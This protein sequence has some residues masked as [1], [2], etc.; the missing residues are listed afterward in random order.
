MPITV[1]I[2]KGSELF[3]AKTE[4]IYTLD[5]DQ[6][7]VLE[8]SLVSLHKWEQKWHDGFLDRRL[9]KTRE[10]A[11][12][13]LKCMTL[14][15]NVDPR[16]YYMIPKSEMSR[17]EE[18]I[19]D[20]MTATTIKHNGRR[21]VPE[22]KTAEVIYAD[23]FML[24]IPYECRKWHLNSLLML[25]QVCADRQQPPKK[26]SKSAILAEN[27]MLNRARKAALHTKG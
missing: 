15:K 13:Y 20:P 24:G 11:L 23:M 6:S 17:V 4:E 12:D 10:Q 18:Y 5:R 22:L 2:P 25:I 1:H 21:G 9:V 19:K 8:H 7:I 27:R 3:N 16:L 26:M 14:S